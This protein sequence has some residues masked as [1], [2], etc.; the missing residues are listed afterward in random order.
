M[1]LLFLRRFHA[2]AAP[3]KEHPDA[4][5]TTHQTG[6]QGQRRRQHKQRRTPPPEGRE[7]ENRFVR[8]PR[9]LPARRRGTAPPEDRLHFLAGERAGFVV[10]A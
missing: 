7:I 1:E 4:P 2:H 8:I 6:E 9:R 10:F 5:S 3:E